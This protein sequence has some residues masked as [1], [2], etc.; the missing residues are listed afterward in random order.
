MKWILNPW[1]LG[2]IATSLLICLGWWA[3]SAHDKG[4][5]SVGYKQCQEEVS[6]PQ[7]VA[8]LEDQLTQAKLTIAA[9]QAQETETHE[10][11]A[12]PAR[13][14]TRA[15]WVCSADALPQT[16]AAAGAHPDGGEVPI[17]G[18]TVGGYREDVRPRIEALKARYETV[19]AHTRA[20]LSQCPNVTI[21]PLEEF[22]P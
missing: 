17:T 9:L 15:V 14:I 11:E 13:R 18:P 1:V 20:A 2:A 6:V 8:D 16:P 5:Q 3:F 7:K 21:E 19:I 10:L 12:I 22:Q 4:Q